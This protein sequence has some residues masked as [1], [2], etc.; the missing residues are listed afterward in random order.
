MGVAEA[1]LVVAVVA[2]VIGALAIPPE[3]VERGLAALIFWKKAPQVVIGV[4]VRNQDVLLVHR[5]PQKGSKL[6][7]QFPA[8]NY[9]TGKTA[10]QKVA[11][12]VRQETGVTVDVD[13]KI[14]QRVHPSSHKVCAYY[15]CR[16]V[17][18]VEQNLDAAENIYVRW[19]DRRELEAYLGPSYFRAVKKFLTP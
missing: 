12:E 5:K 6:H 8:G 17:S 16:Y 14:G 4:V 13:H 9:A 7:W 11:E 15:A 19:V 10:E 1:S 2:T 3:R 18:G